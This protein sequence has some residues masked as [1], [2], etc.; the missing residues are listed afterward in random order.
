M[1]EKI[2][3]VVSDLIGR[4]DNVNKAVDDASAALDDAKTTAGNVAET[5]TQDGVSADSLKD[6]AGQV[7]GLKDRLTGDATE[8]SGIAAQ[9]GT[10]GN[11]ATFVEG[12]DFPIDKD[13]LIAQ[14][15]Q[16]D[17]FNEVVDALKNATQQRFGSKA[18]LLDTVKDYLAK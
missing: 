18:E 7:E 10:L 16:N 2:K 15:T 3:D 12:I 8:L 4:N 13:Q 6:A 1:F 17:A 5:A 14:L 9:L 11:L